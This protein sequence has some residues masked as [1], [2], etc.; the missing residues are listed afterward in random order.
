M[1][2]FEQALLGSADMTRPRTTATSSCDFIPESPSWFKNGTDH[3]PRTKV[4]EFY[5]KGCQEKR[6]VAHLCVSCKG[7][8]KGTRSESHVWTG[9]NLCHRILEREPKVKIP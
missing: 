4:N 7:G 5:K 1:V 2:V 8:L 6:R 3:I 9:I